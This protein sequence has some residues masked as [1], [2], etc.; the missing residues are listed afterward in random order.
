MKR[1]TVAAGAVLLLVTAASAQSVFEAVVPEA[2][3]KTADISTEELRR[4]L[5]DGR[6]IVFDA[7]P[8]HEFA[9]SHIPGAV[10]VAPRPGMPP[11]RYVSDVAEIGRLLNGDRS[12]PIL[13]YCNGPTCGKSRRLAAELLDAGY[14]NVR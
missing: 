2:A 8:R 10:N 7:R 5:R 12:R 1:I 3:P 9:V 4:V 14:T 6:T 11:H 13:L